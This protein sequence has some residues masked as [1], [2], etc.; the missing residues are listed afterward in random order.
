MNFFSINNEACSGS[1]YHSWVISHSFLDFPV[2]TVSTTSIWVAF[3]RN[4]TPLQTYWTWLEKLRLLLVGSKLKFI[5]TSISTM[6]TVYSPAQVLGML[7]LNSLHAEE[8]RCTWQPE[9]SRKRLVPWPASRLKAWVLGRSYGWSWTCW[10]HEKSRRPQKSSW[11]EKRDLIYSVCSQPPPPIDCVV[12][13][14]CILGTV[15]NA[16]KCVISRKMPCCTF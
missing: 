16:A 1:V 9:M 7:L 10:T 13:T 6:F 2:L 3:P 14:Y 5:L 12:Y 11:A 15:N 4:L 8:P